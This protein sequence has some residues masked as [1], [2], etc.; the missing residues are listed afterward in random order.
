MALGVALVGTGLAARMHA[1]ALRLVPEAHLRGAVGTS[2]EKA[3]ALARELGLPRAYRDLEEMLADPEVAVVHLC[4]PPYTHVELGSRVAAAGK[5]LLVDKPLARNVAEADRLIA[6][7]ER[8]GVLLGGLFQQRYV[9]LFQRVKRAIEAGRLG[10]VY[11]ADCYVK[12]WRD[13]AYYRGSSWRARHATEGGGALINQSIHSIDLLQWLVGPV[14]EVTG[15]VA[16]VA[17]EIETEDLGVAVVRTAGG[18]LGVLEGTT[19]AYPGF[20]ERIE[21]HGT[22]GSVVVDEGRRR[23]EWYLRDEAPRVEEEGV[24]QGNAADPAAVSPE[25]HAAAFA[26]FLAAVRAGRTPPVDGREARK[27]LEIVEA[28][29]RSSARGGVPVTLPLAPE[30]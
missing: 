15:R 17:H 20:P 21:L 22:G 1:A 7:A 30:D 16:T 3:E 26:D 28:V 8:H 12:W 24:R 9:P 13:D 18:A 6:A 10:R 2:P 5:H 27:A 29:Y 11:L 23:L 25:A 19:A 4:T 14:V